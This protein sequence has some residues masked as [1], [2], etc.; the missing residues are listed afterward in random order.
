VTGPHRLLRYLAVLLA[1]GLAAA[2]MGAETLYRFVDENGTP[3]FTDRAPPPGVAAQTSDLDGPAATGGVSVT[4]GFANGELQ[5]TAR[6]DSYAPVQLVLDISA[7][8]NVALP[9]PEQPREFLV[10]PRSSM[11]L[12]ALAAELG[13]AAP[14]IDYRYRWLA[15]DPQAQHAPPEPYRAPF[16]LAG[17]HPVTQAWPDT[18]THTTLDSRY[19]IDI[20]MPVGTD[21]V[22]ARG[23]MVIDTESEQF[24]SGFD[25]DPAT[26]NLVRILHD[27]GTFAVY[28]HLNRST[29]RVRPGE[30]VARGDYIADSGNTGYSSGPHL[31]FAVMRN[32]GM[33]FTSVP[34][35]FA[36]PGGTAITAV[37][38]RELVAW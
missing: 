32:A 19:A 2:T 10:A 38:G 27:D 16:A 12:L 22:A 36:G 28:A 7:L 3:V 25:Q 11:Q 24:R 13:S 1:A 21:V 17:R 9:P 5:L 6:N 18:A 37:S 35:Q 23:G 4:Q 15:G 26:A 20:A 34:V 8:Y 29:I 31:H 14:G 30:R 33:R